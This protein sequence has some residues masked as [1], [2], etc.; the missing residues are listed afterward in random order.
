MY[1]RLPP[2]LLIEQSKDKQKVI[3]D[4][5]KEVE[6]A[7]GLS[8]AKLKEMY[9]NETLLYEALKHVTTTKKVICLALNIPL[10]G[11]CRRKRKLEKNGLLVQSTDK[12]RCPYTGRLARSISTNPN[13]FERLKKS[14]TNQLSLFEL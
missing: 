12:V 13:E 6:K 7:T 5:V 1:N 4:I 11:A 10:E 9:S 8:I 2:S 14:N 3:I